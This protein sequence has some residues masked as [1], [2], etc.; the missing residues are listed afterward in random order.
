M[1]RPREI[2][3]KGRVGLYGYVNG[4]NTLQKLK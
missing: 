4:K 3:N 1:R 2:L